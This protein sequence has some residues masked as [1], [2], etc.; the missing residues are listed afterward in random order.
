AVNPYYGRY[1]TRLAAPENSK[2]YE[3]G[4]K[5]RWSNVAVNVALFDQIIKGFQSNVFQG[6]GFVLSNAGK[7]STKGLEIETQYKVNRNL[8]FDIAGTFLDPKYN[9]FLNGP[10]PN[11]PTDLSGT[12]PAGVPTTTLSLGATYNWQ[13]GEYDGFIRADY[14]YES[15]VQVVEN[16]TAAI[17][18]R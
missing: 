16:V 7:Q 11:G 5:A 6:T 4:V 3:I 8:Q 15:K 18:S 2:V 9:S 10:G 1:G 17:A 13:I 12:K 14:R